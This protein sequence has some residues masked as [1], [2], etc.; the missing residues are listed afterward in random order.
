VNICCDIINDVPGVIEPAV[1]ITNIGALAVET[2][3]SCPQ[4]VSMD[5]T[6]ELSAESRRGESAG[7]RV[8]TR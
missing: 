7:Q 2:Y 1:R 4:L 8:V 3:L 5:G 6:F